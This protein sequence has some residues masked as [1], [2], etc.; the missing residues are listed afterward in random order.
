[1][2][3]RKEEKEDEEDEWKLNYTF[4]SFFAQTSYCSLTILVQKIAYIG[5]G[6]FQSNKFKIYIGE[7]K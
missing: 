7:W 5:S 1:M 2:S 6:K 3:A 4:R